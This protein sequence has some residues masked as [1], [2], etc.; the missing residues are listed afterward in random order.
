MSHCRAGPHVRPCLG[1][2]KVRCRHLSCS[3]R[4]TSPPSQPNIRA[5]GVARALYGALCSFVLDVLEPK[6]IP[7]TVAG[8]TTSFLWK[9]PCHQA[10]L[11]SGQFAHCHSCASGAAPDRPVSF[12]LSSFHV[13]TMS[14]AFGS[15]PLREHEVSG[16]GH[17]NHQEDSFFPQAPLRPYRSPVTQRQVK[18]EKKREPS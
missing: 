15:L 8:R 16:A 9:L 12:L 17:N 6:S 4:R 13:L 2:L 10:L 3:C 18:T 11:E 5:G 14:H 1:G 7:W